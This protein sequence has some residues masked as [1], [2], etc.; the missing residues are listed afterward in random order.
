[1]DFF[2]HQLFLICSKKILRPS[3]LLLLKNDNF[4]KYWYFNNRY[5]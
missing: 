1:M 4:H 3:P 5:N 2:K